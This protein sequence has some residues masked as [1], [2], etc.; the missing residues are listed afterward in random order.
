MKPEHVFALVSRH[1]PREEQARRI[2]WLSARAMRVDCLYYG[3]VTQP[4]GRPTGHN[5][6]RKL[7]AQLQMLYRLPYD[8]DSLE[9]SCLWNGHQEDNGLRDCTPGPAYLTHRNNPRYDTGWS[10]LGFYDQSGDQRRGACSFFCVAFPRLSFEQVVRIS[11]YHWPEIWDR[12]NFEV[13][14]V[15]QL[16]HRVY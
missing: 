13:Y 3:S 8:L 12:L 7:G 2:G 15:T 4:G 10:I 5:L 9:P 1:A 16:G 11:K 14:Q 6:Y